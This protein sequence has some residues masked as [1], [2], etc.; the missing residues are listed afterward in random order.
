M[1]GHALVPGL[2]MATLA[3][4]TMTRSCRATCSCTARP[5]ICRLRSNNKHDEPAL[6]Q[7]HAL[8]QRLVVAMLG[9]LYGSKHE[10]HALM[11]EARGRGSCP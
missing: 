4:L 11:V 5:W 6:V 2:A 8:V 7:G 10:S 3:R 9:A 1:Q